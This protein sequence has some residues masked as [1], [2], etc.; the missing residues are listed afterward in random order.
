VATCGFNKYLQLIEEK[1]TTE[2]RKQDGWRKRGRQGKER[3][4][5]V[6]QNLLFQAPLMYFS[7]KK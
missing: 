2:E 5:K 1:K 6:G 7:D 4:G 3:G